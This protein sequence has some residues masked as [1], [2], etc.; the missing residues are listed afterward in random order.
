MRVI[1]IQ[2][3]GKG[4]HRIIMD[5]GLCYRLY[6]K[7]IN[8]LGLSE[9]ESLSDD[10]EE[11]LKKILYKRGLKRVTFLLEKQDRSQGEIELKL[12]QG[13][14]PQEIID[15]I[16][17]KLQEWKLIDDLSYAKEYV[18][19]Y[20]DRKSVLQIKQFLFKKKISKEMIEEA[21]LELNINQQEDLLD[22][23]IEKRISRVSS[24]EEKEKYKILR[25]LLSKGF[26]YEEADSRLRR[27][28]DEAS[29]LVEDEEY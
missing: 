13:E 3:L 15:K 16:I 29:Y 1:D 24:F 6:F 27:K 2:S 14:Y 26:P 9:G 4:L 20:G 5:D 19:Q 28:W 11:K 12:K 25:Y 22:A 7:E 10:Q 17:S 21:L 23:L 8:F 18:H